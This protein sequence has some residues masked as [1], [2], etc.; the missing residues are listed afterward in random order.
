MPVLSVVRCVRCSLTVPFVTEANVLVLLRAPRKV[1]SQ[2]ALQA[3][4]KRS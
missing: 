1:S 3:L 2:K 4:L